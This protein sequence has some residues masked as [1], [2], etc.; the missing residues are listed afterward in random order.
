MRGAHV[1][2]SVLWWRRLFPQARIV[3][4]EPSSA[5]L[6]VLRRNLAGLDEVT[7]LHAALAGTEGRLRLETASAEGSATRLAPDG[8]GEEV[9]AIT[10]DRIL[11]EAS[12]TDLLLAK[13]DVE[14]GEASI[15]AGPELGWLDR[16]R[17]LAVETH[18]WLWPGRGTSRSLW[19]ALAD[20]PFDVIPSG[21][22][23][24]LFRTGEGGA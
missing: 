8:G 17:A 18:D 20:R 21:E 6:A 15:F 10:M 11:A 24:L 3:A 4:V 12:A 13:I 23:L 1:G 2:L 9:P 19:A 16:A 7:V 22:N 14:G 5:N